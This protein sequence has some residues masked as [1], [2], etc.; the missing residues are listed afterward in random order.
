MNI[1]KDIEKSFFDNRA[2]LMRY[3]RHTDRRGYLDVFEYDRLPF[4]PCRS[5]IVADVPP[6]TV[7]GRHMHRSGTQMLVC[8]KGRV[9]ILMRCHHKE[10]AVTLAPDSPALVFRS[11][12]WCQQTYVEENSILLVFA[13]EP[14]DPDSYIHDWNL[15]EDQVPTVNLEEETLPE[16]ARHG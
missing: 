2:W 1:P 7:R 11:G 9:D 12:V 15:Q 14:Y 16:C 8:L 3:P 6:G 10:R 4:T 5:F 13:S